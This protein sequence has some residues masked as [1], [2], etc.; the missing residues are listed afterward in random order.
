M[1]NSPK[2]VL[3]LGISGTQ[4]AGKT[5][6]S[7]LIRELLPRATHLSFAF[8][9]AIKSELQELGVDT[10]VKTPE[11]RLLLQQHGAHKRDLF[12]VDYWIKQAQRRCQE[13]IR[14]LPSGI[15]NLVIQITDVRLPAEAE[16]VRSYNTGIELQKAVIVKVDIPEEVREIRIS[17]RK[18]NETVFNPT[19]PTESLITLITPD[20]LIINDGNLDNLVKKVNTLLRIIQ[21]DFPIF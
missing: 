14:S 8:A 11:I 3:L 5:T 15:E 1:L 7:G 2:R 9:D 13:A 17:H 16:W 10:S 19:D 18:T 21:N 20:F 4:G 6:L 12:G